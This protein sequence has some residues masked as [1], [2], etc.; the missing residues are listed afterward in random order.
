[1]K[2]PNWGELIP[3][4]TCDLK[5]SYP[6]KDPNGLDPHVAGAKLDAGKMLPSLVLGDFAKA[7]TEVVQVGTM[8]ANKY[9]PHGW[10]SVP[11][12]LERYGEA[13]LRH[14]LLRTTGETH[15]PESKLLHRA[16]EAWNVL[17]QLELLLRGKV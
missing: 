7:L 15:D 13:Q 9:T 5:Y 16:H 11:N 17:A 12:G 1:V 10:L 2:E 14:W 4:D 6:D 3:M 8:G